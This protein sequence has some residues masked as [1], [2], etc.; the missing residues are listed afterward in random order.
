LGG[1]TL[2]VKSHSKNILIFRIPKSLARKTR[3]ENADAYRA[4]I[5]SEAKQSTLSFCCAMDCFASLAMTA[6]KVSL[7]SWSPPPPKIRGIAA[8]PIDAKTLY[9]AP[10]LARGKTRSSIEI[11][12]LAARK[13]LWRAV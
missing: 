7:Y 1:D 13:S 2:R 3:G 9:G 4:V 11:K 5:A 8:F 6:V 12:G 10:G